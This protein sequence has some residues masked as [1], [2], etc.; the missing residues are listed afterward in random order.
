MQ[1]G[2]NGVRMLIN[3]QWR[4]G[5]KGQEQEIFNPATGAVLGRVPQATLADLDEALAAAEAGFRAWRGISALER[6]AVMNK[7]ADLMAERRN[8]MARILTQ[9]MGKPLAE[10]R[11][12]ID[13][14]IATTRWYGE[15]GRRAYGRIIPSRG[16]NLRH[17]V[18]KEPVG[19]VI[20]FAAWNFPATNVIR[21]LAGALAAGCSIIIKASSETPATCVEIVRCFQNAGLPPGVVNA[22]FGIPDMIS[23][24]LMAS[25]IAKKVT[26]TGSVAVG[27]HLT[28]LAADTLK[29]CTL[30]LGGHAPVIVAGDCDLPK[31]LDACVAAK[32][33]NAGQVCTSPTRFL[34]AEDIYDTFV[35]GFA[36][37]TSGLK[38]GD[39]LDEGNQMGPMFSERRM[40]WIESLVDNAVQEGARLATGGHRLGNAGH[41]Y[42]PTV[43]RDVPPAAMAMNEEPFAPLA[44][45][46]PVKSLDDALQEANRLPVGLAA[47][48]F[49]RS[50]ATAR[51]IESEINAGVVGINQ[52]VVSLP[53][54]PFGGVNET[55]W[56]SEGGIEGLDTFLRTKFINELSL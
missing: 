34:V 32:F 23:R 22:V 5:S 45:V 46:T 26:L 17:M 11:M 56:G 6:Q 9:E 43:L 16:A 29:R 8:D 48:G 18:V 39:G 52:C 30:E 38:V 2:F 31:T 27:K 4:G 21:K 20:A 7:A 42:A 15:E 51:R 41:F 55:G 25:P 54:A 12:E 3:G 49:T 37:R 13:F 44:L 10:S 36:E 40:A 1:Y 24:H 28:R 33:R 35:S 47:Y 19:P 50:Q 53:E 14:A